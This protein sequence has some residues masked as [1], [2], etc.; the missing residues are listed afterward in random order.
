MW[1]DHCKRTLREK[2]PY[3]EFFWSVFSRIWTEY[4]GIFRISLYS[5]QMRKIRTRKFP[6]IDTFYAVEASL[7][8]AVTMNCSIKKS[9]LKILQMHRKTTQPESLIKKLHLGGMQLY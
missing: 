2:C 7:E 4:G 3:S 1:S 6:N 5:A 9:F 8:E